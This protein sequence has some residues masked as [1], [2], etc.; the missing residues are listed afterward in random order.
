MKKLVS[1]VVLVPLVAMAV[2]VSFQRVAVPEDFHSCGAGPT[3]VDCGKPLAQRR[4][5][6]HPTACCQDPLSNWWCIDTN[7]NPFNCG[8]CGR[9]ILPGLPPRSYDPAA[10]KNIVAVMSHTIDARCV[11]GKSVVSKPD[12]KDFCKDP[13][14]R[15]GDA[16]A[17]TFCK[18]AGGTGVPDCIDLN[19]NFSNCGACDHACPATAGHCRQGRCIPLTAAEKAQIAG[20]SSSGGQSHRQ[21][22]GGGA[23]PAEVSKA[24]AAGQC[25]DG[26]PTPPAGNNPCE[27][28]KTSA[29]ISTCNTNKAKAVNAKMNA[30]LQK[31]HTTADAV[32]QLASQWSTTQC[33]F[34]CYEPCEGQ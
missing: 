24:K 21:S 27:S 23:S 6:D 15:H 22:G 8:A 9:S 25:C 14:K 10:V 7:T 1:V 28:L 11:G 32:A 19:A 2:E 3:A 26:V 30:C 5:D 33:H 17:T 16:D 4:G 20:A 13:V 18:Y 31:S 12:P 34:D 29:A